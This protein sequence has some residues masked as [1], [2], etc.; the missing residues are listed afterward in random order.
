[1]YDKFVAALAVCSNALGMFRGPKR[2]AFAPF[3]LLSNNILFVF[4]YAQLEQFHETVIFARTKRSV[5]SIF[6][7]TIRA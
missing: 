2:R 4:I 3:R 7:P 5:S 1:M 6:L